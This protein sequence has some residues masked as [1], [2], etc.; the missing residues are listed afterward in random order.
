MTDRIVLGVDC[1]T[2]SL[3]ASLYRTDGAR[4]AEASHP[5]PTA[6][7]QPHWAEQD[8]DDWWVALREAV[9]R[10]L[11]DG[12]VKG[13]DVAA[14]AVDGTSFTG[15]F[16]REDGRPLRPALLWMDIRAAAEAREVEES[17]HPVLEA[18]GGRVSPEWMLPKAMW[19]ARNEPEVYAEADRF[20]EGM[21]W[22][23]H[24][25]CG[26]WVT[27]T[28]SAAG[29]RH[30]TP[31]GGWPED[32]YAR[33]D[34]PDLAYKSPD[35]VVYV[36]DPVGTLLPE[37]AEALG[38]SPD[39][40]VSHGGMDG[41]AAPVGLDCLRP[42][43]AALSL[44]TSNVI[45]TETK[46]P[47]RIEGVMGPF[48]DGIRR[49]RWVYEAGQTSG[50]SV[51]D[52]VLKVMGAAFGDGAHRAIEER[53]AALPPGSEGLVVFDAFQGNRTPYFDPEARGHIA[54]LRLH[55][56]REHLYRAVLEGCA[57]GMRNL[58][59]ALES[60]GCAIQEVRVAG[61]G[62]GNGL[63][64]RILAAVTGRP[65]LV[66]AVTQASSLGAAACAAVACGAHEGLEAAG[67]AMAPAFE[68][69]WPEDDFEV[70]DAYFEAYRD[71]YRQ[72]KETMHRLSE[73]SRKTR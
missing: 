13:S 32:L 17:G 40:I 53:A 54:G 37:A 7:P 25:L 28:G 21:D 51:V 35:E 39:C 48:P 30:W 26:R 61:S 31:D 38:L 65:M 60:G 71:T 55:H 11:G 66:P 29:K 6:R 68:T 62:A 4:L 18:C 22:V 50:G 46:T 45:V 2:H 57:Y 44:G 12:G 43:C 52:W 72:M 33:M 24:R 59:E 58:F 8:P 63:L 69:V 20:V 1:G 49:D 10:C 16:C 67:A 14:I 42:G 64:L 15:V 70:Y 5:F 36:G 3:R 9:G 27:A 47:A 34:L 73:A 23:T 41:W 19:V 56:D